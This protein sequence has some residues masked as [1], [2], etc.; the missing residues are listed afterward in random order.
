MIDQFFLQVQ[1]MLKHYKGL[2]CK[3]ENTELSEVC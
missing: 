2:M 1:D 3:Y